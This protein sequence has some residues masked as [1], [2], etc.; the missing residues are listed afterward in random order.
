LGCFVFSE[1][2]ERLPGNTSGVRVE[3]RGPLM[4]VERVF[5]LHVLLSILCCRSS[6]DCEVR[7]QDAN[8]KIEVLY[9]AGLVEILERVVVLALV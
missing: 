6:A 1:L 8:A 4:G 7:R 5:R 9:V 3:L 2:L